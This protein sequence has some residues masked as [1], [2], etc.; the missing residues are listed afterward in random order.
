MGKYSVYSLGYA[1]R[2]KK[3]KTRAGEL[4]G[5][6]IKAGIRAGI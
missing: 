4:S 3:V 1:L 6:G 5:P 2:V